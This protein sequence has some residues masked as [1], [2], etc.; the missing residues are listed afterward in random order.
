MSDGAAILLKRHL[1]RPESSEATGQDPKVLRKV[2][3]EAYERL[4]SFDPTYAWTSG[5]WMT[6]RPGGSDVSRTETLARLARGDEVRAEEKSYGSS[7]DG[8]GMPL[9]PWLIDGF[10]WFSSAT[11]A[12]MVVLLAQ[13]E[14]GLSAFYAPMRRTRVAVDGA[15]AA[16]MNGVRISRLKNKL[17]TKGLPTAE[18]EIGG[19]RAWLLGEE[20]RG[21]REIAA[22]LN[23]TR[24]WTAVGATGSL[25]RGL[26]VSRSYSSVRT[27][28]GGQALAENRQ[29]VRWM[30]NETVKYRASTHLAFLGVMLLGI[31]EQ[32]ESAVRGTVAARWLPQDKQEAYTLLRLLTPIMKAQCSSAA[33]LG[34]R[35]V[36]ESLGGVG[37]C[38]N[39]EDGGLMNVARLLRDCSVNNIWEGTTNI[40]AEDFVRASRGKTGTISLASIDRLLKDMVSSVSTQ[41][42]TLTMQIKDQWQQLHDFLQKESE[43][44]LLYHGKQLLQS[45]YDILCAVLLLIDAT[46][47]KGEVE[48]AAAKRWVSSI[49]ETKREVIPSIR[50]TDRQKSLDDRI[51]F[52]K[53]KSTTPSIAPKL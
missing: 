38:E 49:F 9:G 31:S 36:M 16:V 35:E 39:N 27:W 52:G 30:A 21:V 10:K 25:A 47:T 19:M 26:A 44:E 7:E 11:D 43:T 34:L 3:T 5:Q 8:V 51:F 50:S 24:L 23:A 37:Y 2:L 1:E 14:K 28:K 53:S 6:E 12:D 22:I 32:G 13:T 20:G 41:H 45:M 29:H 46:N 17:G 48:Q 42:A 15:K 33:T 40:L 18:L 4:T